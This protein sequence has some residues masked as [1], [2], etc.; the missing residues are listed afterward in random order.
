MTKTRNLKLALGT[1]FDFQKVRRI[2]H[3]ENPEIQL[4]VEAS[5]C[6]ASVLDYMC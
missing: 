2:I 3:K 5:I 6:M 1:Q 4:T